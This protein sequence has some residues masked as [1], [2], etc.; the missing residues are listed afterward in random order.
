MKK[1]LF[2]LLIIY[3]LTKISSKITK[4]DIQLFGYKK[5]LNNLLTG[6]TTVKKLKGE[7]I[8][9]KNLKRFKK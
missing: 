8:I 3:I 6:K 7:I 2:Y 9:T 4:R 5:L 1:I